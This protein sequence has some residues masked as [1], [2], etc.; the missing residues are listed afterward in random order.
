MEMD[1]EREKKRKRNRNSKIRRQKKIIQ[2][3]RRDV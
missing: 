3:I 1:G 2:S